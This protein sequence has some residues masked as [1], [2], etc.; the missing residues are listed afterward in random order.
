MRKKRLHDPVFQRMERDDDQATTGFE[1]TLGCGQ[2]VD[3]LAQLLV[4][5]QSQCLKSAGRRMDVTRPCSHDAPND[6]GKRT[7]GL[8]GMLPSRRDNRMRDRTGM[9]LLSQQKD[10]VGKIALGRCRDSDRGSRHLPET[11]HPPA[12][13]AVLTRRP[14]K[15]DEVVEIDRSDSSPVDGRA[16]ELLQPWNFRQSCG[17][18]R[19]RIQLQF[20]L[21]SHTLPTQHIA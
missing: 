5:E 16:N 15:S 8:D 19:G 20:D 11:T 6:I 17:G 12:T 14:I 10:D 1:D 9:P 21:V 2:A 13:F 18:L 4:H 3:E 7:G